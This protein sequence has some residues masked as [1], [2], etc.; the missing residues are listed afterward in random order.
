MGLLCLPGEEVSLEAAHLLSIGASAGVGNSPPRTGYAG[1]RA[2]IDQIHALGGKAFIC[3]PYWLLDQGHFHLPSP[4]YDRILEEG[5]FDGIEL[6]GDVLLED[7]LRSLLRFF[8]LPHHQRPP[9]L[10]NSDTHR[11][12]H[13]YGGYWTL[14]LVKEVTA[15]GILDAIAE[16]YSAACVRLTLAPPGQEVLPRLLPFGSFDLA[17]LTLFL[18]KVYFPDHD[19]LCREQA[20]LGKRIL[21]GD[22][23]P[24]GAMEKIERELEQHYQHAWRQ[25]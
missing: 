3:H 13:T 15:Q 11:N 4:D 19:R 21:A 5:G 12:T 9:I 8:D 25:R 18:D 22:Q 6:L 2:A 23:L 7:N 16:G 20:V 17:D 10:G 24:E 1:L 14:A